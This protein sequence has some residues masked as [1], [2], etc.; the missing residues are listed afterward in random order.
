MIFPFLTTYY[1]FPGTCF[2]KKKDDKVIHESDSPS[3]DIIQS[4]DVVCQG[5]ELDEV[6]NDFWSVLI[7]QCLSQLNT[8]VTVDE[9]KETIAYEIN[10]NCDYYNSALLNTDE[11]FEDVNEHLITLSKVIST[12]FHCEVIQM[13]FDNS[14]DI[15]NGRY[16]TAAKQSPLCFG[17]N[18]KDNKFYHVSF[19]KENIEKYKDI[20][21]LNTNELKYDGLGRLYLDTPYSG[22]IHLMVRSHKYNPTTAATHITDLLKIL[23]PYKQVKSIFMFLADGGPDFNLA[24]MVNELFYFRLFKKLEADVLAVMT[25]AARYSA[26]NPINC[27]SPASNKLASVTFSPLENENDNVA[28]ALQSGLDSDTL[29]VKEK[30]FDRAMSALAE[31]HWYNFKY[32]GF[33]VHVKPILVDKDKLLFADYERV[34]ACL[35]SP[36]REIYN[37]S[38]IISEFK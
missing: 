32:D 17:Y 6:A 28:C 15:T 22:Q 33:P 26:F 23:S 12:I 20:P 37:Y 7:R 3:Y 38:D 36:I 1:Q 18:E 9:L 4:N 25:Y 35:K 24:H 5:A 34:K 31:E 19:R 10:G 13:K 29:K 16:D 21:N 11:I 2:Y 27:W 8:V 14:I 30:V